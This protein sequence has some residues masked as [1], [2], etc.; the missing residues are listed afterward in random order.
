MYLESTC[1]DVSMVEWEK[2][3]FG[4]KK[5][6]SRKLVKMIKTEMPELYEGLSLKYPNPYSGNTA[7]TGTHYILVHSAIEYFIRKGGLR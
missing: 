6:S 7:E 4:A 2:L 5:Y 3:M 1:A